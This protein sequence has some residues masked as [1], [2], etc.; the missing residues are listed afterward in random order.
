MRSPCRAERRV[1][2][3][4]HGAIHESLALLPS[5]SV[6]IMYGTNFNDDFQH[7]RDYSD[8]SFVHDGD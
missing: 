2:A 4:F 1:G 8:A 5:Q 7:Q 6:Q 3:D